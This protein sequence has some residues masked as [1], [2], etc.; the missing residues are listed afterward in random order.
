MSDE[1]LYALYWQTLELSGL[2][3]DRVKTM[4]IKVGEFG[5]ERIDMFTLIIDMDTLHTKPPLIFLHGYAASSALYYNMYKDLSES[6]SVIAVD[7]VG[8]GAS[9]R[10]NNFFFEEFT[11]KQTVDYFLNYL[12]AW[13]QKF[14][15]KVFKKELTDFFLMGHSF[16][17][18]ISGHYALQYPQHVKKLVLMSPIGIGGY[19]EDNIDDMT[20]EEASEKSNPC[21]KDFPL[22]VRWGLNIVWKQKISPYD[23]ARVCGDRFLKLIID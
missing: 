13:R 21:S 1:N 4:R 10:P 7:H 14:S 17:G 18:F 2:P 9:S 8:M 20:I 22:A 3:M 12:E 19:Q 23:V 5:G 15:Q 16:G 11:P 6:F